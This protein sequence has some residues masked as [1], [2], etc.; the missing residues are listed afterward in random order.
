MRIWSKE[1]AEVCFKDVV[2]KTED[3]PSENAQVEIV[4][5]TDN[6]ASSWIH[7]RDLNY[8]RLKVWYQTVEEVHSCVSPHRLLTIARRE[9]EQPIQFA[10]A[11]SQ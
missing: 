7:L 5:E 9:Q 11:A 6:T 2:P 4:V 1:Q 8:A 10:E 3:S